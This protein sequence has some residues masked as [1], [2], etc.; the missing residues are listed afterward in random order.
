MAFTGGAVA[1]PE[2]YG[3]GAKSLLNEPRERLTTQ[4]A[5]AQGVAKAH[6]QVVYCHYDMRNFGGRARGSILAVAA[7]PTR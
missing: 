6:R 1:G 2:A 7:P 3:L 5:F 4:E